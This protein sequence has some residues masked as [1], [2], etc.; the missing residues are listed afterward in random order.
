MMESELSFALRNI[1]S[2]FDEL[3]HDEQLQLIEEL[4]H[5]AGKDPATFTD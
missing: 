2:V 4:Q 1:L 5:R 3:T